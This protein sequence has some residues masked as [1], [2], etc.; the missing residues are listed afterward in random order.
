MAQLMVKS[1]SKLWPDPDESSPA[2]AELKAGDRVD[3]LKELGSWSKITCT[4]QA[5]Q[6]RLGWLPS[7]LLGEVAAAGIELFDEPFGTATC[8]TGEI[9]EKGPELPPWRKV[10]VRIADGTVIRGWIQI[11]QPTA[12]D[13]GT[14][15]PEAAEEQ[16]DAALTLG[17]NEV[18][19]AAL[20]KAQRIT[21]IDAAALAALIDAEAAKLSSGQWNSNSQADSSSAAGLTQFLEDTWLA[22]SRTDGMTLNQ[23]CKEKLY[24]STANE[25][26]NGKRGD[27]LQLRFDP[28]LSIISAAEYG[29]LNLNVLIRQ[30]LVDDDVGD[31]EKA[32]S[33]YL[34]HHEGPAGAQAFLKGTDT[35]TFSDLRKQVG[36]VKAQLYVNDAGGDATRAY[37]NWLNDYMDQRIQ[38]SK[39]RSA[40]RIVAAATSDSLAQF[41]RAPIPVA[42]LGGKA[43]LVKAIQWRLYELGYLDPPADGIFGPVSNWALG[44]FCDLNEV[45]LSNGM[46]KEVAQ[47]LLSPTKPLADIVP[48]ASWFDK[49]ISYMKAQNYFICRHP[50]CKNIVYLEG[51]NPD[52]TL[53]DDA[54]NKFNDLRIVFSV[55][56][57]GHP[58]FEN[59]IWEGT[60]E[61]G[62]YWTIQPMSPKGAARIAFNQYKSWSVGIHHPTRPSAHEALVQVAP[63]SVYRDLNQDFKRTGDLLDTGLFAINQHWGYDA[64]VGDLGRSSAGCLVGRTRDGHRDFM[65]L[66]KGDPRYKVNRSY[67]FVTAV[68]PGDKVF[69]LGAR[70]PG[71]SAPRTSARR[72]WS[73]CTAGYEGGRSGAVEGAR[74]RSTGRPGHTD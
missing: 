74:R 63:V 70:I 49:V 3:R 39:F 38:P 66:V 32:R 17:A 44:E 36:P 55:A 40:G 28:D 27:I 9:V 8:V 5:G 11:D 34:A 24:L 45:S 69:A 65:K 23:V 21:G 18:Y 1:P 64:P 62:K 2:S 26:V 35:Y 51:V 59:S 33:I 73:R 25:I 47:R 31:D 10:M 58:A 19:R 41:D 22:H 16:T 46:T 68:I 6:E 61:P 54:P 15:E 72:I 14:T 67:R 50:D 12:G 52:G 4:D 43:G 71:V 13:S 60:T 37:R 7:E 29:S 53:N 57:N 56:A 20:L 30:G 48:T 42:E